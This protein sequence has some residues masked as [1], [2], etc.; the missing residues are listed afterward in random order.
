MATSTPTDVDRAYRRS[1]PRPAGPAVLDRVFGALVVAV[2]S[3]ALSLATAFAM[4][5]LTVRL[6]VGLPVLLGLWAVGAG[7]IGAS[8]TIADRALAGI[9]VRLP[10]PGS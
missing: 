7:V 9:S 3:I 2:S 6:Q 4:V 10:R 1:L 5:Y 8:P